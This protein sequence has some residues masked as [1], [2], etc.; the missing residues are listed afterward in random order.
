MSFESVSAS[1]DIIV[2]LIDI[3]DYFKMCYK[4][5]GLSAFHHVLWGRL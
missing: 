1:K 5:L 2:Y 4:K 3:I